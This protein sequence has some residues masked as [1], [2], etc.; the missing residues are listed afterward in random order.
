MLLSAYLPGNTGNVKKSMRNDQVLRVKGDNQSCLRV[1]EE[2]QGMYEVERHLKRG[3][4]LE[5]FTSVF[6]LVLH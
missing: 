4:A 5:R 1:K 6:K 2:M 3:H